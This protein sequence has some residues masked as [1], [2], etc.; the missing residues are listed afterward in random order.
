MRLFFYRGGGRSSSRLTESS[1]RNL[2]GEKEPPFSS[3]GMQL[4]P[5]LRGHLVLDNLRGIEKQWEE[6][7]GKPIFDLQK[8]ELYGLIPLF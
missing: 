8:A 3:A 6:A 5:G 2:P 7:I 4:V 1:D